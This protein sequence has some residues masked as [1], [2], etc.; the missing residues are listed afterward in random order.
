MR[1]ANVLFKN[2]L[3]I[4]HLVTR[5]VKVNRIDAASLDVRIKYQAPLVIVT[6]TDDVA[7]IFLGFDTGKRGVEVVGVANVNRI[8]AGHARIDDESV[9]FFAIAPVGADLAVGASANST[10]TVKEAELLAAAIPTGT[11]IGAFLSF[12]AVDLDVLERFAQLR[13]DNLIIGHV[14]SWGLIECPAVLRRVYPINLIPI[15][16]D[17]LRVLQM[18]LVQKD[19]AIATVVVHAL[20]RVQS[21]V[22]PVDFPVAVVE[23]EAGGERDRLV[24]QHASLGAVQSDA[25]D[26]RR[27]AAIR[28]KQ[29]ASNGIDSYRHRLVHVAR[30][31]HVLV[32]TRV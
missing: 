3:G 14:R 4:H 31:N 28:P 30:H 27:P 24:H 18:G 22:A 19:L 23:R 20:D 32:H 11:R 15:N 2:S 7:D 26:F 17:A 12:G 5:S 21:R 10:G 25:L 13:E 8:D 29:V 16:G 9:K 1:H 6:E